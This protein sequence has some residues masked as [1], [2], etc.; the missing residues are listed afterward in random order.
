MLTIVVLRRGTARL[1]PGPRAS[2][3]GEQ[4]V[5]VYRREDALSHRLLALRAGQFLVAL[6]LEAAAFNAS[7]DSAVASPGGG[8]LGGDEA[9]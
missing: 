9:V 3:G 5:A 7:Q 1:L 4:G 8:H 6:A 2:S